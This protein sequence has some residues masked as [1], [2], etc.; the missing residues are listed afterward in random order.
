M[1]NIGHIYIYTYVYNIKRLHLGGRVVKMKYE[2]KY[3]EYNKLQH[4]T[5][6]DTYS[7][8]LFCLFSD[9]I[10]CIL[11]I[12]LDLSLLFPVFSFFCI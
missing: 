10:R 5:T 12:L 6:F 9:G 4:K 3:T 11:F 8:H 7:L 1:I 2:Y